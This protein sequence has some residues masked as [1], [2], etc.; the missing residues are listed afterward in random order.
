MNLQV[1]L[2]CL[3][4]GKS[5]VFEFKICFP[6]RANLVAFDQML[7]ASCRSVSGNTHLQHVKTR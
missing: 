3:L 2:P 4:L 1:R 5:G 7:A 6:A